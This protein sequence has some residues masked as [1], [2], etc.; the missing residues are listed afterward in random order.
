MVPIEY[1]ILVRDAK[2]TGKPVHNQLVGS[3]LLIHG[4]RHLEKR[5][6]SINY[7]AIGTQSFT[8]MF[9]LVRMKELDKVGIL[10]VELLNDR[11]EMGDFA[12]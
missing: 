8:L 2:R 12:I 10:D 7:P 4:I 11:F 5:H 6:R 3:H 1:L 9:L